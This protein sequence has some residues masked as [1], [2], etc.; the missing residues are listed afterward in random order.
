M[1]FEIIH[2]DVKFLVLKKIYRMEIKQIKLTALFGVVFN[3]LY[4]IKILFLYKFNLNA[5]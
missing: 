3:F 1:H 5:S 4:S 2:S